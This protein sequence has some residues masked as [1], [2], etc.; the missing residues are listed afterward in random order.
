MATAIIIVQYEVEVSDDTTEEELLD[1]WN[2]FIDEP[3]ESFCQDAYL[4]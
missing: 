2:Y 1:D 3:G 4:E